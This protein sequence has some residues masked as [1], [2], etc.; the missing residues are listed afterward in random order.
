MSVTVIDVRAV[1]ALA[2]LSFDAAE[3]RALMV[4]LNRILGFMEKLSEVETEGVEPTSHVVP[5]SNAFRQDRVEAFPRT[6][7][8]IAAAP[9][10][11]KGYFKVPRI[12]D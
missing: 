11:H 7:A 5:I 12:I 1:A 2:R 4:D 8:I 6:E 9:H 3:E 10:R